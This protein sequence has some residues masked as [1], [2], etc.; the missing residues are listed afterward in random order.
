MA[1]IT[2]NNFNA[3]DLRVSKSEYWDF[4]LS[5]QKDP[6]IVLDGSFFYD[7]NLISYIDINDDRCVSGNSIC[8]TFDYKWDNSVNNGLSLLNSGFNNIDNGNIVFDK[9]NISPEDFDVLVTGSSVSINSGDTRLFLKMISGN[10]NDYKYPISYVSDVNGDYIQLEGGFYQGFFKSGNDYLILPDKIQNEISFEFVLKPDFLSLPKTDTLNYKYPENKGIFFYLGLRSENKFWYEYFKNDEY[11]YVVSKTGQTSPMTYFV[12]GIT[13]NT[14]GKTLYTTDGFPTNAQNIYDIE[15]DNKYLLF[16]RT[17]YGYTAHNFDETK[18]YHITGQTRENLNYYLDFNRTRTGHTAHDVDNGSLNGLTKPYKIID[19]VIDNAICF[20]IKDDGSVG[21]RTINSNCSGNT[22]FII[23][24]EYSKANII[25]DNEMCFIN[26][27]MI[28]NNESNLDCGYSDRLFKLWFYVNGKLVFVSKDISE[29]NLR[30]INDTKEKQE[31]IPYNI[32]IGGGSQGLCD[33]IGFTTGSSTQYLF[34]IE[35]YFGG[36]LIGSVY[37]FR[38]YYGKMDYSKIKNNYEFESQVIFNP[39]YIIPTID[40]WL[41]GT[42]EYPET[43]Y[44]RESGNLETTLNAIIKLNSVY[45]PITGY[46]LYYFVN[47]NPREQIN[48]LFNIDPSGGTIPIYTHDLSGLYTGIT[49]IRYMIEVFDTYNN[50]TGTEK[51]KDI[52][53]DNMIFYGTTTTQPT[54]STDIRSLEHKEF[55]NNTSTIT[56]PTGSDNRIFVVALPSNRTIY[57]V[58]DMDLMSANITRFF[59]EQIIDVADAGGNLT[60]YNIYVMTNAI[61]YSRNHNLKINLI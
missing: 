26:V 49:N 2:N 60:P 50:I 3:L 57:E 11:K 37:K 24:E 32:S 5:K 36:S 34:P 41:S 51:I 15:T 48:G 9:N 28:M 8:S 30:E 6:S 10:T 54:G 17:K 45:N 42:T 31:T 58:F 14:T 35:K 18:E 19:D 21:Y 4:I 59:I 1:N 16:N 13:G 40:F 52:T 61:P 27:R 29:L 56:L 38:A 53:F 47:S 55:S 39:G 22:D 33:M 46:K 12:S 43:S 25:R 23:N 20:R 7:N 44:K